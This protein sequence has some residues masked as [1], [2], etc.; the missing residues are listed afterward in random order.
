[1]MGDFVVVIMDW[2]VMVTE[3]ANNQMT[4]ASQSEIYFTKKCMT[5]DKNK[6]ETICYL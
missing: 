5:I 2:L 6:D 4:N 3:A 1:M